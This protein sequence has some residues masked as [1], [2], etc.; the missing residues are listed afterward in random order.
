VELGRKILKNMVFQKKLLKPIE[1]HHEDY[2]FE[3]PESYIVAAAEAVVSCRPGA[4]R[5][6]IEN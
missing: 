4:R 3:T 1:P 6:S 2:P 5:D